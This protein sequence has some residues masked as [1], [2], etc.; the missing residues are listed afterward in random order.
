MF[1]DGQPTDGNGDPVYYLTKVVKGIE[2]ESPIDIVG[3]GIMDKNVRRFYKEHYIINQIGEL[4][5][6]LLATIER[7]LK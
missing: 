4:E 2:Q 1:S 7:K 6:A 5:H 3:I